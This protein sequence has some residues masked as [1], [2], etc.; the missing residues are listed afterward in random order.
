LLKGS[1]MGFYT[2]LKKGEP[3]SKQKKLNLIDSEKY[4]EGKLKNEPYW[5]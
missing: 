3:S 4:C 1:K 2:Y 5:E